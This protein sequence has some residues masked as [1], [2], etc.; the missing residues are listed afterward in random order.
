MRIEILYPEVC[1]L[2]GDS[3]N[4]RV[5]ERL[6]PEAE[7]LRTPFGAA[8]RFLTEEVSLVYMG[9]MT[10]RTQE[11]ILPLLM[12]HREAI[13]KQVESGTVF[14]CT[15]NAF[16]LF[17]TAIENEDGSRI[18]CLDIFPMTAK[19]D[20]NARHNSIFLGEFEGEA[21][22]GFK[23]QFSMAHTDDETNE[24]NGLFRVTKG[25]GLGRG[26]SFEGVRYR[27]FFGTYLIGPLLVM[28][29]PFAKRLL[30]TA[31]AENIAAF[32]SEEA[33]QAYEARLQE[34]TAP[35]F[36]A[37]HAPDG[38]ALPIHLPWKKKNGA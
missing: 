2:F 27:N 32:Y 11:R 33:M 3:G 7:V 23:S 25:V 36:E 4:V 17:G 6:L 15:G 21:V 24:K 29:P 31:G 20:R 5:L 9:A 26:A 38:N 13:Q 10:E 35:G 16:E 19:R 8:P 37:E 34:L 18:Q 12:P 30:Q 14:L 22:T 1:N 28:N